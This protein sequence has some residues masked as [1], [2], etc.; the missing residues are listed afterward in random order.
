MEVTCDTMGSAAQKALALGT[1]GDH[2]YCC[3]T[4]HIFAHFPTESVKIW[5]IHCDQTPLIQWVYYLDSFFII[6]HYFYYVSL[7]LWLFSFCCKR[8][9]TFSCDTALMQWI[10]L[11]FS[12]FKIL[13]LVLFHSFGVHR[14]FGLGCCIWNAPHTMFGQVCVIWWYLGDI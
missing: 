1:Y 5:A 3:C 13:L 10:V 11:S 8:R 2:A 14:P 9:Y 7:S 12:S 6:I 4:Y